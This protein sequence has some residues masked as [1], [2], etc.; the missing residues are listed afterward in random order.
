MSIATES[1]RSGLH[2]L[3]LF[4]I[5]VFLAGITF[6]RIFFRPTDYVEDQIRGTIEKFPRRNGE[7]TILDLVDGKTPT[8]YKLYVCKE[9]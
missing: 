3:L 8:G 2:I 7:C 6:G 9:K 1:I 4:A 5:V